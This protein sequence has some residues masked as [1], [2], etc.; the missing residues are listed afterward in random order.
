M[1]I[2][3]WLFLTVCLLLLAAH[4]LEDYCW[5]L[6]Y[7]DCLFLSEFRLTV[8]LDWVVVE[9]FVH[10]CLGLS[11]LDCLSSSIGYS[12]ARKLLP[13]FSILLLSWLLVI[14]WLH[15]TVSPAYY[16]LIG[17]V[18]FINFSNCSSRMFWLD[19][20]YTA[21]FFC[22]IKHSLTWKLTICELLL[23]DFWSTTSEWLL[24]PL[25]HAYL[26]IY[27]NPHSLIYFFQDFLISTDYLP[28][29]NLR[30]LDFLLSEKFM[31]EVEI[32]SIYNSWSHGLCKAW[33]NV[34]IW[35]R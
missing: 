21:A 20:L 1:T 11:L 25:E 14:E 2:P 6:V 32:N 22:F 10:I 30:R 4:S 12:L 7:F 17:C 13:V 33:C 3:D 19:W 35:L 31:L 24:T 16:S 26:E 29:Q 27:V 18:F 34:C 9:S 8:S 15:L 28:N 5:N 23:N